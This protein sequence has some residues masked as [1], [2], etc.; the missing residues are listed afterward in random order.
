MPLSLFLCT[1][2]LLFQNIKLTSF[3]LVRVLRRFFSVCKYFTKQNKKID[4]AKNVIYS[5][6]KKQSVESDPWLPVQ[7]V[8]KLFFVRHSSKTSCFKQ[9]CSKQGLLCYRS[10]FMRD[11]FHYNTA[12]K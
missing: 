10:V 8:A 5:V 11:V 7:K 4:V 9:S 12:E 3:C 6:I 1:V 2:Q